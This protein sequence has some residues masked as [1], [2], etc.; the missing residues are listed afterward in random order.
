MGVSNLREQSKEA[1]MLIE[2][3]GFG[4]VL[5]LMF[6][7]SKRPPVVSIKTDPG[8]LAVLDNDTLAE[9]LKTASAAGKVLESYGWEVNY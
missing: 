1:R 7:P 8:L 6:F 5:R 9:C 4:D 2:K 3:A